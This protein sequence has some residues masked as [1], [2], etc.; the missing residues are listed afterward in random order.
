MYLG[1]VQPV[2]MSA[3]AFASQRHVCSLKLRMQTHGKYLIGI[4]VDADQKFSTEEFLMAVNDA[5]KIEPIMGHQLQ[6]W[7]IF[8]DGDSR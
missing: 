7:R 5:T 6:K 4:H 3:L 8:K 2:D 1:R